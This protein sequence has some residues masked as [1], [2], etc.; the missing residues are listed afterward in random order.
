MVSVL[1]TGGTGLLDYQWMPASI[2]SDTLS[3]LAAGTY[4]VLITDQNGCT[5]MDS[6]TV[7]QP[8]ILTVELT[9][10]SVSCSGAADGTL[11][12][13]VSGG[14]SGYTYGWSNG[15][16]NSG[17]LTGVPAGTYQLTVTD[18]NGCTVSSSGQVIDPDPLLLSVSI[19]PVL[20]IGQVASLS[21][22]A[23]GG[24]A[25]YTLSWSSGII[26]D[27]IQVSPSV[28]TSYSVSLTDANGCTAAPQ[29]ITVVVLPP[30][31]VQVS[32]PPAICEGDSVLISSVAAGGDGGPYVYSWNDDAILTST[33]IV[34]PAADS[35][36]VV[37][38]SD[39]CSPPVTAS[40]M[41]DVNPLPQ[42][43]ITPQQ[44]QGCSPVRVDFS[45]LIQ[46]P[47]GSAYAWDLDEVTSGLSNPSHTY[48]E[49]G[50]YDIA[51][52]IT[53]PEGC[54]DQDTVRNAI[55][56]F[57]YPQAL[58]LQSVESSTI[59]TPSVEL[60]DRSID[61]S[62]WSWDFGD[63]SVLYGDPDPTHV[64]SDSGTYVIMLVVTNEGGCPDTVYGNIRIEP[65][66]TIFIPNAF[67]PNGD[68]RNDF[69]IPVGE[70]IRG[71]EMWILD[72]WGLEI[73]H[74]NSLDHPWDG[75]YYGNEKACQNDVYEYVVDAL[76]L[77]G[78]KRRYI[79]HVSLVR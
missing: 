43:Q 56:V 75:T 68:G 22:L 62:T 21:A 24:T 77:S 7:T 54:T 67:T 72:R 8:A 13:S 66:F 51:L 20:C 79:G 14:V 49:P 65:V 1:A 57:G 5:I 29:S 48:S 12:A 25:P 60:E 19:P 55:H 59:L 70:N 52:T 26:G 6:A 42:V 39:G 71:F 50:Y 2:H 47:N 69:F 33:A 44:I 30:L 31:N 11:V 16:G 40:A 74:S 36:F 17:L 46:V 61:A 38:V 34:A 28:T 73:F 78:K 10:D 76:D 37:T 27:S 15:G 4:A 18:A 45:N 23:D 63:G 53:T 58:F 3:L 35:F 41:V 32:T 9:A 64:Y